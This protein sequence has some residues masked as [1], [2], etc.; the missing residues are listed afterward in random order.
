VSKL[1]ERFVP[2]EHTIASRMFVPASSRWRWLVA[3]GAHLGDGLL[4]AAIGLVLAVWGGPF[5]RVVALIAALAVLLSSALSTAIKY[6]IRRQRPQALAQF[7]T[8]NGDRY[9]FPSGHATRMAA[10]A[11]VFAWSLPW[12]A[13]ASYGLAVFVSICRVAVGVHYPSDVLI[14]LAIGSLCAVCVLLVL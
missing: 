10:I 13:P 8:L 9:S 5:G 12:L 14:G 11:T 7:Y 6:I 3:S 1:L 2:L 4:W